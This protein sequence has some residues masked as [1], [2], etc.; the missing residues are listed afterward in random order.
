M[1]EALQIK[2]DEEAQPLRPGGVVRGA[3]LVA[4]EASWCDVEL[5]LVFV[6]A[7]LD[8]EVALTLERERLA[9]LPERGRRPFTLPIPAAK[10]PFAGERLTLRL[11]LRAEA[12]PFEAPAAPVAAT[13]CQLAIEPDPAERLHLVLPQ[14]AS[15]DYRGVRRRLFA[16]AAG[17]LGLAGLCALGGAAGLGGLYVVAVL[18]GGLGVG[19]GAGAWGRYREIC[20]APRFFAVSAERVA[21]GSYRTAVRGERLYVQLDYGAKVALRGA[22]AILEVREGVE[23]SPSWDRA[24]LGG[25]DR[26]RTTL[27][28]AHVQTLYSHELELAPR[29]AAGHYEGLLD[30]PSGREQPPPSFTLRHDQARFK[31]TIAWVLV[32]ETELSDGGRWRYE[33]S[34]HA[35]PPGGI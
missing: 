4:A 27:P 8:H 10:R 22:K 21:E 33:L 14:E 13:P 31:A 20:D 2:L 15:A 32:L 19:L 6:A 17:P 35:Q 26:V 9:G 34:I 18:V 16:L 23:V 25:G 5:T 28:L 11:E 24:L 12:S 1:S 30:V 29:G 3:V 7:V